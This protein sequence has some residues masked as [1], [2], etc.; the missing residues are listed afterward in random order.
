M[1]ALSLRLIRESKILIGEPWM[2]RETTD[3]LTSISERDEFLL[4]SLLMRCGPLY[5]ERKREAQILEW[6][7]ERRREWHSSS[8]VFFSGSGAGLRGLLRDIGSR[9][10]FAPSSDCAV[11]RVLEALEPSLQNALTMPEHQ[12]TPRFY[13]GIIQNFFP[14]PFSGNEVS[15]ENILPLTVRL[16]RSEVLKPA[17]YESLMALHKFTGVKP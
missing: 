5:N 3:F 10:I 14:C 17:G 11:H 8:G 6:N 1:R 12:K 7:K 2:V 9:G 16:P 4:H 13:C 15:Q